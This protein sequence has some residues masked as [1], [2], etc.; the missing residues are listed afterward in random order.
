[1]QASP[2]PKLRAFPSLGRNSPSPGEERGIWQGARL[3]AW[4]PELAASS[5]GWGRGVSRGTR[6]RE[7]C[8]R[9][10]PRASEVQGHTRGRRGRTPGSREL[11]APGRVHLGGEGRGGGTSTLCPGSS[12]APSTVASVH[13]EKAHSQSLGRAGLGRCAAAAGARVWA[14]PGRPAFNSDLGLG[15]AA[16]AW[17]VQP[18]PPS[19]PL[20]FLLQLLFP[21]IPVPSLHFATPWSKQEIKRSAIVIVLKKIQSREPSGSRAA[22]KRRGWRPREGG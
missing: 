21:R 4:H 12:E 2:K 3:A 17:A 16:H 7:N 9:G 14:C 10:S 22:A 8:W 19:S 1:M 11:T 18:R 5:R 6:C 13:S 15:E 20:P